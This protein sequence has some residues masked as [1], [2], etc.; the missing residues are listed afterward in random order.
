MPSLE[1]TFEKA[2]EDGVFAGAV[3]AATDR[4]G[5]FE[6]ARAFGKRSLEPNAPDMETDS[7]LQFAS[8][9]KLMTTIAALQLVEQGKVALDD[10]VSHLIPELA[11][12]SILT[13]FRDDGEPIEEAR[14]T[15]LK[16]R[17]LLTH[18]AGACYEVWNPLLRK[19]RKQRGS[20]STSNATIEGRFSF[21]LIYQ[22]GEGWTYSTSIDWAGRVVER[23]SGMTLDD[24]FQA[25]ICKPLGIK[26]ITFWP[27][28][29]PGMLD[30]LA[31]V[32]VRKSKRGRVQPQAEQLLDLNRHSTDAFGGHGCFGTVPEYLKV[33][34]SILADDEKLLKR[35]TTAQMFQP[36]L[37]AQGK[38]ALK[39]AINT[40]AVVGMFPGEYPASASYDWGLGGLLVETE[41]QGVRKK[42]TLIW[43]GVASIFWFIDREAG[44]C[45]VF[46]TQVLPPGDRQV[47]QTITAFE[48]AMNEMKESNV[49]S[50][51]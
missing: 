35:Q 10:D 24:Y 47:A 18:S 48:K 2:V 42:N 32:T 29:Q 25:H 34:H 50:K 17:Y 33:L 44:L 13:G 51:L 38:A 15:P 11:G 27:T 16:L 7:V 39:T 49:A 8:I 40:P 19:H 26:E 46:G 20:Q 12:Q 45:G 37:N 23:L 43:T 9:T 1:E 30:R 28:N 14:K 31:Q 36:Q 6:Y 3:L 4:S 22:P 21:P 5:R 41:G